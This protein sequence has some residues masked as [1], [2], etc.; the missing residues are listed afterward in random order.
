MSRDHLYVVF[1]DVRDQRRWRRIYKTMRGFGEWVQLS[2]FQCRLDPI[3]RLRLEDAV[4]SIVKHDEDHVLIMDLGPA[5]N[6]KPKVL[7]IGLTFEPVG[8]DPV[9]V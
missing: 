5:D 2:V 6:V 1:Y 7:S 9:V 4:R 8:T 3:R